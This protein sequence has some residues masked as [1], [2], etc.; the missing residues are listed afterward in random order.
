P[1]SLPSPLTPFRS[2]PTLFPRTAHA[3][4]VSPTLSLHDALPISF[5]QLLYRVYF[6]CHSPSTPNN[7]PYIYTMF[8]L[9][10]SAMHYPLVIVHS[11]RYLC[12]L[13]QNDLQTLHLVSL[14]LH[15]RSDA[16]RNNSLDYIL[17]LLN[18]LRIFS[19]LD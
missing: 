17:F 3:S 2:R 9:K 8:I 11:S 19:S 1:P 13:I 16:A 12:Y 15:R 4:S 6:F 18:L 10:T 14:Y 7:Q 5:H